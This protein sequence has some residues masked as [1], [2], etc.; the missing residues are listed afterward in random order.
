MALD[1]TGIIFQVLNSLTWYVFGNMA[2]TCIATIIFFTFI[3][4]LIQIPYPY[5]FAL[6][7]P[8]IAVL[9]AYSFINP[10]VGGVFTGTY[11]LIALFGFLNGTG[12]NQ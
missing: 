9:T 2:L 5:A 12:L 4:I 6:M 3:A 1:L 10:L 11:L 8:F 7:I